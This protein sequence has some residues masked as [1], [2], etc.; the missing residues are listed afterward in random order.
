MRVRPVALSI[1]GSDSSGGAG[2]QADLKT[3][4]A[5]GVFGATSITCVVAEHPGRVQSVT[6]LRA[7]CVVDQI[8]MVFESYLVSAIKTGMLYSRSII[9]RV[10]GALDE[11]LSG[12]PLVIDP[13]MVASSGACLLQP[14]AI[15]ALKNCLF[16]RATLVTPNCNEAALLWGQPIRGP[17]DLRAAAHDL[18]HHFK[19]PFLLKGGHLHH[20]MALDVLCHE[21]RLH[22]FSVPRISRLNLHGT[23][24][25]YAAAITAGLALG[26][27]LCDAI[28]FGKKYITRA[29]R[30]HYKIG[31]Y[32]WLAT[33]PA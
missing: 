7:N 28:L 16:P 11:H 13:V 30:D 19:V 15:D 8:D 9:E 3:F 32:Q 23:G 2:I 31:K 4:T 21:D 20:R 5:L 14:N 24:C 33:V 26:K 22:E 18:S 1:A 12:I 6:P 10:A 17:K 25:T 27:P 29:I